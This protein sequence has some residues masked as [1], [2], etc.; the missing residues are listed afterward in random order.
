MDHFHEK[1]EGW[2]DFNNLYQFILSLIEEGEI[3]EV[4]SWLGKSSVFM[5][6]EIA[7]SNKNIKFNCVDTWLGSSEH[8]SDQLVIKNE[9]YNKFLQN[10]EPV[11][12]YINP[13]RKSS[14]EA[15]K[16]FK[17]ESLD[18]IFIDA[19]HSYEDVSS[20]IAAWYPKLKKGGYI[21]GH[22]YSEAWPGVIKAVQEFGEKNNIIISLVEK[23]CWITKKHF[24]SSSVMVA[25]SHYEENLSWTN[26]VKY[27]VE[28]YSKTLKNKNFISFNKV[29]E[30][31]AYLKYIIE[32][33]NNLPEYS[34]FVHGHFNS[35]HQ[36]KNII[37]IINTLNIDDKI[38]NLN[39]KDWTA[40][41]KKGDDENDK[42]FSWLE[43]NW[44]DLTNNFIELPNELSFPACAQ[45]AIHKSCI[46]RLPLEFWKQLFSWCEN[47]KLENYISSRIFEYIWYYLFS[48]KAEFIRR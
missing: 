12:K 4:G 45:F 18:F 8:S 6:V 48:G 22:D 33:Y 17:D 26:L 43:D 21:G 34:I 35:L 38:I 7:N 28:I 23:S 41:I 20:D 40:S 29:Q 2:F 31:P 5:A 36:D 47:N 16:D 11:K 37:E 15:A 14:V 13:V 32:N 10:I 30:A 25:S 3:V 24:K 46:T 39:R 19:G 44:K 1:I 27:P 9:L 42:K